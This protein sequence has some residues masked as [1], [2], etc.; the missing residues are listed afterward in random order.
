MIGVIGDIHGC[1]YTLCDLVDAVREKYK[2]I[3]LYCVGDL[4]DRGVHSL[5]VVSYCISNNIK[6]TLGNHD[7]MFLYAFKY[8][9]H[10]YFEN[11]IMNGNY[12]T[13]RS[14]SKEQD[15]LREHLFYIDSFPLFYNLEDCFISHAGISVEYSKQLKGCEDWDTVRWNQF[16]ALDNEDDI[17][18]NRSLLHN[19]GKLQIVGHTKQ[20]SVTFDEKTNGLYIDTG[21]YSANKLSCVIIKSGVLIETISMKSDIRDLCEE[22]F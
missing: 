19:I 12:E 8:P 5:P 22:E 18:W 3:E 2:E 1:Y 20:Q 15:K 11:W 6:V 7:C 17:F 21:A 14:Y 4:I 9:K 10:S 13:I 16:L